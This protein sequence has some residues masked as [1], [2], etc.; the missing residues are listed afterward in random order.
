[1]FMMRG[2]FLLH[3]FPSSCKPVAFCSQPISGGNAGRV[4][5]GMK[6]KGLPVE[7]GA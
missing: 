7:Q 4:A 1:M 2:I 3:I 6:K 5:G